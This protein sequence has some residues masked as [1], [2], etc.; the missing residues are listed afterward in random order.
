MSKK[1]NLVANTGKW[2]LLVLL[3]SLAIAVPALAA[4]GDGTGG[5]Q[6]QPL[7]LLSSTPA[8]GQTDVP[9]DTAI[10]LGFSKNVINMSV[11]ENNSQCFALWDG[12][13]TVAI[14]VEMADDQ[15]YPEKKREIVIVPLQPLQE[16]TTYTLKIAPQLQAKN[17]MTLEQEVQVVFTTAGAETN[18]Q[19]AQQEEDNSVAPAQKQEAVENP[20]IKVNDQPSEDEGSAEQIAGNEEQSD[21]D[22]SEKDAAPIESAD[23]SNSNLY[24][25][26][27]GAAV[28]VGIIYVVARRRK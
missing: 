6:S 19:A 22:S 11:N 9:L 24:I 25:S 16:G 17:G 23:E 7:A 28:L 27:L 5:G 15:I 21:I 20:E 3:L 2:L 1:V 14:N 13:Q 4:D 26:L 10:V 12:G 18:E 8:D